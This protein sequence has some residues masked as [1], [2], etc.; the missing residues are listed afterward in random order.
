AFLS[1]V[2]PAGVGT[3]SLVYST[4]LGGSKE[5]SG[6]AVA[7][8]ANSNAYVTGYTSSTDFPM[9]ATN[10]GFHTTLKNP[11]RNAFLAPIDQTQPQ[12]L[13]YS[14]YLGGGPNGFGSNPPDSGDA[15]PSDQPATPTWSASLMRRTIPWSIRWTTPAIHRVRKSLSRV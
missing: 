8:D 10:T 3:G 13:V 4:Y 1:R 14:T 15:S 7:V 2:N 5:D 9:V 6:L 11:S 12:L